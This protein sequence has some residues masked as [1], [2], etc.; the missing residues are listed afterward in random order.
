MVLMTMKPKEI[1]SGFFLTGG[2]AFMLLSIVFYLLYWRVDNEPGAK[3]V[4]G[5]LWAAIS[6]VSVGGLTFLG[7]HIYLIIKRSWLLL[8]ITWILCILLLASAVSLAPI[9]L[10][11]MV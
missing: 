7:S 6:C 4:P 11:L 5:L 3:A 9:L 8:V 1:I 10:L 2:W